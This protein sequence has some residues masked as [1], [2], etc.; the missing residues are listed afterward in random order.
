[1][2]AM[3]GLAVGCG[4]E[5]EGTYE[6]KIDPETF[7]TMRT[8]DVETLI[9]DSGV[10]RY[11]IVTPLWLV[12][13]EAREPNWKFPDG[14]HLERFDNF[15]NKEA[16]IDCDSATYFK[17]KQ[18]W[19]LDGNVRVKNMAGE[20]FRTE[21]LFWDQRREEVYSDSF[22]QIERTDR[23]ME[24]YGFTSNS[25]MTQFKVRNV[26][27]ILPMSQFKGD[28]EKRETQP[29]DTLMVEDVT[30]EERVADTP[31]ERTRRSKQ[32]PVKK[33]GPGS[34]LIKKN[35]NANLVKDL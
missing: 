33:N 23:M 16:T 4:G 3:S 10:I 2:L 7:A 11:K 20:K 26:S 15:F 21:Q 34:P 27:A 19:R 29:E 6:G 13:D 28:G 30:L 32:Q 17:N 35:D 24:G 5:G 9:S 25:Q 1:M 31:R 12:F 14:L 22:I 8:H 18:L